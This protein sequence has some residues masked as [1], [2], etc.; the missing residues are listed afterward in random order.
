[1]DGRFLLNVDAVSLIEN[2][3]LSGKIS[4]EEETPNSSDRV[5]LLNE[6]Q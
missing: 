3:V 4:R 1:M 6:V 5:I 2:S